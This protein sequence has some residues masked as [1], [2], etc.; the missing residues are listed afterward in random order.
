MNLE[1]LYLISEIAAAIAVVISIL[2]LGIQIRN[3]RLQNKNET[4]L[5]MSK[6]RADLL[7]RL[8]L[9]KELSLIVA[10]GLA[11]KTKF[12]PSKYVRFMN[13]A[14]SM[15]ISLEVAYKKSQSKDLDPDFAQALKDAITWWLSYPGVQ[16]FWKNNATFGFTADFVNYVNNTIDNINSKDQSKFQ[17][18]IDFMD[19]AGKQPP[20]EQL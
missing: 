18:S 12:H 5:E 15:F 6:F 9:D 10:Q 1:Q 4:Y 14:V 16:I 2:Y 8:A 7:Y 19:E 20:R 17:K 13:Y 3:T 11:A